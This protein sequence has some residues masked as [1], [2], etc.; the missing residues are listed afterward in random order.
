MGAPLRPGP[1]VLCQDYRTELSPRRLPRAAAAGLA[2]RS[3]DERSA[4]AQSLGAASGVGAVFPLAEARRAYVHK[5]ERGKTVLTI[6][7]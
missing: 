3:P 7:S 6:A 5:P 4:P 2:T 1:G